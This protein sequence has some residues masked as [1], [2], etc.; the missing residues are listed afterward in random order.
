V[1]LIIPALVE[2]RL[3][4]LYSGTGVGDKRAEAND[5]FRSDEIERM[6]CTNLLSD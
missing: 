1:H 3:S 6:T 2:E 4:Y 5:N